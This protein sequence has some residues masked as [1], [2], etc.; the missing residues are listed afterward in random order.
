MRHNNVGVRAP[1]MIAAAV[2]ATVCAVAVMW[3]V[4]ASADG[5]LAIGKPGD[6]ASQ[7]FAFGMVSNVPNAGQAS[8]RALDLC[9]NAKG[10][11]GDARSVCQVVQTIHQQCIA[12]AMDPAKGTPGAGWAVA[13]DKKAAESQALAQCYDTAGADRRSFCTISGSMCDTGAYRETGN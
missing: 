13:N 10:A 8:D 6:V 11:S 12:V 9:R 4:A 1:L 7:G 3:P 5:A 2:M